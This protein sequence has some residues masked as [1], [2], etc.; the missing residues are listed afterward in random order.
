MV[1]NGSFSD[2]LPIKSGVPQGSDL[3]PLLFLIY[4][5]DLEVNIKSKIKFFVGGPML[6]SV[7]HNP[8]TSALELN[9]DLQAINNWAYQWKMSFNSEP[10]KQAVEV[11][12]STKNKSPIHHPIFFNGIEVTRVDEYKHLGL[13]PN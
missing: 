10:N 1:L 7:V 11:M 13:T 3:G 2:I 9:D 12:F 6:F 5:N 8:S 4:I